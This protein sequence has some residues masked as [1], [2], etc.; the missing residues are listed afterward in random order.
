MSQSSSNRN[1]LLAAAL[2]MAA[3]FIVMYFMPKLLLWIAGYNE[4]V[5]YATGA[6][7]ILAFFAVFWLRAR[8][9]RRGG[10]E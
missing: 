4:Y 3:V 5:A 2:I 9:Q 8:V 7:F 1:A 10:D 6:L